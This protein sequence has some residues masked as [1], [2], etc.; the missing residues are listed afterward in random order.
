MIKQFP[1]FVTA[2]VVLLSATVSYGSSESGVAKDP[3]EMINEFIRISF[4]QNPKLMAA[5]QRWKASIDGIPEASALPDPMLMY[6]VFPEEIET[7]LGPQNY[8]LKLNQ[9]FPFLSKLFLRGK[10]A[11]SEAEK[12]LILFQKETQDVVADLKK[13]VFELAYMDQALTI[14][15]V[16]R[17][18][19]GRIAA[20]A[21]AD[22]GDNR[23]QL[24]DSIRA[25]S[26]LSQLEYDQVLM[27]ELR[28]TEVAK[29]NSILHRSKDTEIPPMGEFPVVPLSLG[30]E[31]LIEL[32]EENRAE[33][34][35]VKAEV[36][37][38]RYQRDL[39]KKSWFPDFQLSLTYVNIGNSP[40][41]PPD[42]GRDAVGVGIGVSLPIWFGK[43]N[44]KIRKAESKLHQAEKEV[45]N[46]V[47]TTRYNIKRIFFLTKN[48]ERLVRL[49]RDT[50]VP[51]AERS[52]DISETLYREEGH[53][54]SDLLESQSIWYNFQ[55]AKS[56]ALAD[57]NRN[58]ADLER[59]VGINLGS[60]EV[61]P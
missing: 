7:R 8:S 6:T 13:S 60:K 58:L 48:S 18:L 4:D 25:E 40:N 37:K 55:L 45:E 9:K 23:L 3:A 1:I 31:D 10:V 61:S 27:E 24:F 51:Q 39:A 38:K 19:L 15:K 56:R 50:L 32:A 36:E 53:G 14:V 28:Q 2:F 17:E 52:L 35:F 12:M 49:Y 46:Q 47:D 34:K 42:S 22:Y 41:N 59:W 44:S 29:I 33:I 21:E 5:R 26:Q 11:S 16:N 43:N 30:L 20:L 54:F 57:Y